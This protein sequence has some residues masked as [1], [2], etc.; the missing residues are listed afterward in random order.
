MNL[1]FSDILRCAVFPWSMG[2]HSEKTASPFPSSLQL[3]K[4]LWLGE[5]LG[6]QPPSPGW[7]FICVVL[8]ACPKDTVAWS[9]PLPLVLHSSWL[10]FHSDWWVSGVEDVVQ[11]FHSEGTWFGWTG[12]GGDR[13]RSRGKDKTKRAWKS[14]LSWPL[15]KWGAQGKARLGPVDTALCWFPLCQLIKCS[16]PP[17]LCYSKHPVLLWRH[18]SLCF[19]HSALP[20]SVFQAKTSELLTATP[21]K[22]GLDAPRELVLSR[23]RISSCV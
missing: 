6:N 21:H 8:P 20:V 23:N 22:P 9:H 14:M 13:V 19:S 11:A 12:F 17:W 16:R 5:G 4:A 15:S 10:V 2:L 7:E 1:C 18:S 3:A